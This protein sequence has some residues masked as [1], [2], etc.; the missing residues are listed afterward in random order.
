MVLIDDS[1]VRGTTA[2]K[3]VEMMRNAGATEVH[4]RISSPPIKYPDFYGIDTPTISE[5]IA[6]SKSVEEIRKL[7]KL[8]SLHFLSLD[9]LYKSMGH[10][11]RDK[12]NPQLYRS[13]FYW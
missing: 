6:S 2:I 3:I 7:L 9:G 12:N 11:S 10:K 4:M 13:L 5:L 1:I 8:D